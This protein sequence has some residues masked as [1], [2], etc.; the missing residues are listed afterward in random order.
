MR[1]RCRHREEEEDTRNDPEVY[2]LNSEKAERFYELTTGDYGENSYATIH[3]GLWYAN[4]I[5]SAV[6]AERLVAELFELRHENP[7]P[8]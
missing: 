7:N 3:K 5:V 2:R 8:N 6:K 1:D 4:L